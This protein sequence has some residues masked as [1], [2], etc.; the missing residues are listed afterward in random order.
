MFQNCSIAQVLIQIFAV[1]C[2]I[3]TLSSV[4]CLV[5]NLNMALTMKYWLWM[6]ICCEGTYGFFCSGI[7]EQQD[8]GGSG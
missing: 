2:A 6:N 5:Q 7:E 8:R 4:C 1:L 3:L